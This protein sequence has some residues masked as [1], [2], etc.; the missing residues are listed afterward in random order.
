MKWK[1]FAIRVIKN[2]CMEC[3]NYL[4]LDGRTCA[5]AALAIAANCPPP[6]NI[7]N[8]RTDN[9]TP[10]DEATHGWAARARRA[11]TRK[12]GLTKK[13]QLEIQQAN[14]SIIGG[15]ESARERRKKVLAV[16]KS[17]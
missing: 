16:L 14:D 3:G 17:F 1:N 7:I 4:T 8:N 11:I 6:K 9:S 12:F 13:Q 5:I 15:K 10:I 2:D